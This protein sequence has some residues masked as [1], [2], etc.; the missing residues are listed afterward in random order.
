MQEKEKERKNHK[1]QRKILVQ[2]I[3]NFKIWNKK[4]C[5]DSIKEE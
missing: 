4:N 3:L 5:N 2:E 1:V